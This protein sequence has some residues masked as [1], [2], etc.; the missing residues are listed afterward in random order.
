[1]DTLGELAAALKDNQDAVDVL[2]Q[3]ITNKSNIT[4][5]DETFV[6][7]DEISDLIN[8]QLEIAILG[9]EW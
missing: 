9:G 7:K 1:M 4:Y 3:A 5:V 6:R 2:D 8:Q